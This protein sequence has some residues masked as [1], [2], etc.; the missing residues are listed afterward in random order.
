VEDLFSSAYLQELSGAHD[1]DTRGDLSHDWQ[2]VGDEDISER[3]FAL[4]L[5]Q[6]E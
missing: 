1:G 5:L 4:E 2:A 3:E 6:E